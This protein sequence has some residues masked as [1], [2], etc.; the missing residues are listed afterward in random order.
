VATKFP[1]GE[2]AGQGVTAIG[3]SPLDSN[4]VYAGT[5]D[6]VVHW[7]RNGGTTWASSHGDRELP[8]GM[9]VSS[10]VAS[11]AAAGTA[12]AA[13]NGATYGDFAPHV[14]RTTDFGAHWRS[15]VDGLP[16]G[17]AVGGLVEHPR[18]NAL[19]FAATQRGVFVSVDSGAHWQSL[20]SNMPGV[21][22]FGIALQPGSN[23]LVVATWGRGVWIL[24]DITPL[25]VWASAVRPGAD[26]LFPPRPVVAYA[27]QPG[28]QEAVGTPNPPYGAT[29]FY[30]LGTAH[31]SADEPAIEIVDQTGS[32]VHR[33]RAELTPGLHML[34]WNLRPDS[35]TANV[36]RQFAD[37]VRPAPTGE[38]TVRLVAKSDGG[39]SPPKLLAAAQPLSVRPDPLKNWR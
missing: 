2:T 4:V 9:R 35:S 10:V 22:V 32:V 19:L 36:G 34:T 28:R 12:Y 24:E 39:G 5:S 20:R 29:L 38:Y 6:G 37:G 25:E 31:S 15:L 17:A 18:N 21:A 13:F 23:E 3:E 11:E 33:A 26:V 8:M 1:W 30:Y 16:A 7:T 14:Y 27:E